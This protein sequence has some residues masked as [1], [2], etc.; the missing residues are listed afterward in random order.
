[1]SL[2]ALMVS[3]KRV[4]MGVTVNIH[5]HAR[6]RIY[7]NKQPVCIFEDFALFLCW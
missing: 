2:K 3:G 1:M 5:T 7:I 4:Q 6:M